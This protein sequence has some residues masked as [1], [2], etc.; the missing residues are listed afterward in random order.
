MSQYTQTATVIGVSYI[1]LFETGDEEQ[2]DEAAQEVGLE[3]WTQMERFDDPS[4]V[5]VGVV[6]YDCPTDAQ[7]EEATEKVKLALP[8]LT[9]LLGV[10]SSAIETW[11]AIS[12]S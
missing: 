11:A 9:E 5:Y 1:D 2:I 7:V 10:A 6:F 3:V 12:I 4:D 8:R